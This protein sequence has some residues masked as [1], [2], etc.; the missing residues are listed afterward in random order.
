MSEFPETP[1]DPRLILKHIQDGL[2]IVDTEGRILFTNAAFKEMIGRAGEDLTGTKC[3]ELGVG[4]FC[5]DHCPVRDG[6][7][8]ACAGGST[9]NVRIDGRDGTG[10]PGAYCVVTSPVRGDDGTILGWFENFRGMDRAIDVIRRAEPDAGEAAGI[11][12]ALEENRWNVGRTAE[13]LGISR[14]TLWRRMKHFGID[15][16]G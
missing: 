2:L 5:K 16:T 9:L 3:C 1:L 13:A 8:G 15:R 6:G 4:A 10:D 7:E 11:A 12:R 14:T